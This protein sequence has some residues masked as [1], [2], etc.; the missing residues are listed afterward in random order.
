MGPEQS[1]QPEDIWGELHTYSTLAV[2]GLGCVTYLYLGADYRT[3]ACDMYSACAAV[4]SVRS[5]GAQILCP[6]NYTLIGKTRFSRRPLEFQ[7]NMK[8]SLKILK[9]PLR[10]HFPRIPLSNGFP[11]G[12]IFPSI[13]G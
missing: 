3:I 2:V 7:V 10:L 12:E 4:L 8:N 11:Q 9:N 1:F 6:C 13:I 5:S